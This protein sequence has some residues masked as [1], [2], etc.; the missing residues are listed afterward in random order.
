M[1][2]A[3]FPTLEI[4]LL[5]AFAALLTGFVDAVVGGGGMVLLPTLFTVL[6]TATPAVLLG[7]NKIA[8]IFGTATAV[9]AYTKKIK[10]PWRLVILSA[11]FAFFGAVLG[12]ALVQHLPVQ[13]FRKALPFV[14]LSLLIY[15]LW[16]K[17][18]GL[19]QKGLELSIKTYALAA[20]AGMILGFYDGVFGPGTGSIL[21]FLWIKLF[22][23]DFL[24][25]STSAKI[26]NFACN[27]GALFW[28]VP[29]GSYILSLGLWMAVFTVIGA[30][31]GARYSIKKGDTFIRKVFILVVVCLILRTTYDAFIK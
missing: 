9:Y 31:I 22:Q 30:A 5:L 12:A 26:V 8:G 6:P 19:S 24:T 2:D 29:H 27:L 25:A 20:L 13:G 18:L 15:T 28:F 21:V 17:K 1:L 7:T 11:V 3:A 10:P 4:Y 16:D 23:L 14:L